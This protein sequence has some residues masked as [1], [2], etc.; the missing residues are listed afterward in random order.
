VDF[1]TDKPAK[2]Q[3]SGPRVER[4]TRRRNSDQII[5]V[6]DERTNM[7]E[8]SE[9]NGAQSSTQNGGTSSTDEVVVG[10][11]TINEQHAVEA[12]NA[13][14]EQTQIFSSSD[15]QFPGG[16]ESFRKF[17]TKNL[18][19]PDDLQTDEKK[20]VLVRFKVDVDGSISNAQIL[21]SGGEKYDTEVLR[22][23]NKMP[24]WVPATQNGVKVA[25]WFTQPVSFIGV[26]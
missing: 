11:S 5:I 26:E 21:K 23:L 14:A 24:K 16:I 15:A 25:T 3:P 22:V 12:N 1:P 10:G 8:Q 13:T 18:V 20:T 19:T 2:A 9:P 6:H 17:L 4:T 7:P